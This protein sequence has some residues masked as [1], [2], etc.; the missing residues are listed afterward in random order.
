MTD[1]SCGD[2]KKALAY[3]PFLMRQIRLTPSPLSLL[4]TRFAQIPTSRNLDNPRTLR[5]EVRDAR[6][7]LDSAVECRGYAASLIFLRTACAKALARPPMSFRLLRSARSSVTESNTDA[8]SS[9]RCSM[10]LFAVSA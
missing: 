1:M 7:L 6:R 2:R 3:F 5:A 8:S 4:G 9:F 10:I